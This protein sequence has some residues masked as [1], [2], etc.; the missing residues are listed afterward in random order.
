MSLFCSERGLGD[1]TVGKARQDVQ[2]GRGQSGFKKGQGGGS[3]AETAE[4]ERHCPIPSSCS[5]LPS[6][7]QSP[8]KSGASQLG[9]QLSDFICPH[10]LATVLLKDDKKVLEVP[11]YLLRKC[12]LVSWEQSPQTFCDGKCCGSELLRCLDSQ[13]DWVTCFSSTHLNFASCK[14]RGPSCTVSSLIIWTWIGRLVSL[15]DGY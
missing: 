9:W 12:G 6:S 4:V 14:I 8:N 15:W 3:R 13:S 10:C 5:H 7:S 2:W 11:S 1:E